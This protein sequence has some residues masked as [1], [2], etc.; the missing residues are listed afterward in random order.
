MIPKA[1]P[2]VTCFR[3]AVDQNEN[4]WLNPKPEYAGL[5]L[6]CGPISSVLSDLIQFPSDLA[7]HKPKGVQPPVVPTGEVDKKNGEVHVRLQTDEEQ[8]RH[9]ERL[10]EDFLST[11]SECIGR[12]IS[13]PNWRAVFPNPCVHFQLGPCVPAATD[14]ARVVLFSRPF[15]DSDW[16]MGHRHNVLGPL[17][18]SVVPIESWNYFLNKSKFAGGSSGPKDTVSL[19]LAYLERK[20]AEQQNK[21]K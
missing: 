15:W 20:L 4:L 9:L 2:H 21:T 6:D 12:T 16:L 1:T 3:W 19:A 14:G 17:S 11:L 18:S 10:E 13:A 8:R 5:G 7:W